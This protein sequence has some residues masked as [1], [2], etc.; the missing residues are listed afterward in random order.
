MLNSATWTALV[1]MIAVTSGRYL[2]SDLILVL[3]K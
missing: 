1:A 3:E 2:N